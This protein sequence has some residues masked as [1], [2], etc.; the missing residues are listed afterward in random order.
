MAAMLA[1]IKSR[2]LL[3]R[4]QKEEE[5]EDDP[6]AELVRRLQ[7]YERY[8]KAAEDID[9]LPRVGRELSVAVIQF[10]GERPKAPPPEVRFEEL[11]RSFRRVLDRAEMNR[12]HQITRELL[13]VRERMTSV[14]ATVNSHAFTSFESLFDASEGRMGLV[15]TFMAILELIKESLLVLQQAEPY[16]PIHV[17][18]AA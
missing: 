13:S 5:E 11:L 12:H 14:L 1:E 3:P 7:E 8:R 17:K 16:A 10:H 2:M 18:A 4:P 15:V 9:E 6:R